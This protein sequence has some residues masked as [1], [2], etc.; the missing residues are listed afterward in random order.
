MEDNKLPKWLE[1][2][3]SFNEASKLINDSRINTNN[4]EVA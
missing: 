2:R 4:A 1:S 3:N